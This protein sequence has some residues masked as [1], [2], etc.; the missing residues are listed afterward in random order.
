MAR[1]RILKPADTPVEVYDYWHQRWAEYL[2]QHCKARFVQNGIFNMSFTERCPDC[3]DGSGA[4][5]Y[6]FASDGTLSFV[7]HEGDA[8]VEYDSYDIGYRLLGDETFDA[9]ELLKKGEFRHV[10]NTEHFVKLMKVLPLMQEAF[11]VAI[12][13]AENKFNI[14]M[15]KYI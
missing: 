13:D 14:E 15:P 6:A 12:A 8:I 7:D 5:H 10:K 11:Y 9:R 3:P 4:F 2:N 1:M